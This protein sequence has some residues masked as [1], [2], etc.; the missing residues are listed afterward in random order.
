MFTFAKVERKKSRIDKIMEA[1]LVL[2][3]LSATVFIVY[4][5]SSFIIP[6]MLGIILILAIIVGLMIS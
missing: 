6:S 5:T 3:I 4:L 1:I 2:S